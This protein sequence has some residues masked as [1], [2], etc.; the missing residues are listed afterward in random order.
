MPTWPTDDPLITTIMD[1][2][3]TTLQGIAG[4][5]TYRTTVRPGTVE[6]VGFNPVQ[7]SL[8]PT[9]TLSPATVDW[10]DGRYPLLGATMTT[11]ATLVAES[12]SD[13]RK[14]IED[15]MT[16]A[17]QALI[18]D[19]TRGGNARDTHVIRSEPFI[20]FGE[21]GTPLGFVA[22]DLTVT[23]VFAQLRTNPTSPQ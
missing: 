8:F 21:D 13:P 9:A 16:D 4:S 22:A 17:V 2:L 12:T 15:F 14:V 3:V 7:K 1:D 6:V 5:P 18:A 23:V 20:P 19:H 11:T 10:T